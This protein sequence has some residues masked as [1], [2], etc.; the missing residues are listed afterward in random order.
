MSI[1]IDTEKPDTI[2]VRQISTELD[3]ESAAL[4]RATI[5]PIFASAANWAGLTDVLNDK[6]YGLVFRDGR[7]CITDNL[8]G[9][10][11]CGLRFLGLE[12]KELVRRLGRPIVVA[13]GQQADGDILTARPTVGRA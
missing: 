6:G 5:L 12:F 2:T 1:R 9:D 7:M 8:T 10:R 3:C 4:L 11:V 13:R